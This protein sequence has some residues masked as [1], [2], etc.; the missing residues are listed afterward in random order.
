[1]DA[2]IKPNAREQRFGSWPCRNLACLDR[3]PFA[4]LVASGRLSDGQ[5]NSLKAKLK[6][7]I[8]KIDANLW[9]AAVGKLGAFINQV[10]A[11]DGTILTNDEAQVLIGL[12]ES[13]LDQQP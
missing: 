2:V 10:E 7:I 8:D 6:D 11:W 12:A 5:A 4:S 1:M 13:I 9:N 3:G